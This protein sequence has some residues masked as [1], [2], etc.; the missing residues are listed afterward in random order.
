MRASGGFSRAAP[1][2]SMPG[3]G[4]SVSFRAPL[5]VLWGEANPYRSRL[6]CGRAVVLLVT[7]PEYNG[8]S[9]RRHV[10]ALPQIPRRL[11]GP[12]VAAKLVSCRRLGR[13]VRWGR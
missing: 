3:P 12:V 8:P 5:S 4:T 9:R 6:L 2:S 7:R 13:A 10:H 1:S 11:H